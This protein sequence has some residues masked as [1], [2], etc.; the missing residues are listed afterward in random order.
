MLE[1]AQWLS[2]LSTATP[3]AHRS[4][5]GHNTAQLNSWHPV[6]FKIMLATWDQPLICAERYLGSQRFLLPLHIFSK[7]LEP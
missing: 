6:V 7:A 2:D 4:V 5:G 3:H 1:K